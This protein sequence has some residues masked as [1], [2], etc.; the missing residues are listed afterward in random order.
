MLYTVLLA[1]FFVAAVLIIK[2]TIQYSNRIK[3]LKRIKFINDNVKK[4]EN[5]T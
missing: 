2:S 4:L 5:E 1:F 3:T